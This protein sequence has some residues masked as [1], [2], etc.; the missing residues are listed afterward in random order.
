MPYPTERQM[1]DAVGMKSD[2]KATSADAE[3]SLIALLKKQV[4][5]QSQILTE[6]QAI[7]TAVEG[8]LDVTIV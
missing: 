3:A 1:A 2:A 8:T 7:K 4:D 6:L 5:N